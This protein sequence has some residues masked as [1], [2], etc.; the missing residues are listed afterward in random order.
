MKKRNL[1]GTL[2]AC[3]ACFVLGTLSSDLLLSGRPTEPPKDGPA[4]AMEARL[5]ANIYLQTS[6]EYRA[7]CQQIYHLAGQRMETIL[8][9]S[10][11]PPERPAVVM[12]L[13]ETVLDNSA[14]QTFLYKNKLEYTDALWAEFEEKHA[15]EVTFIPGAREFITKANDLGVTVVFISNRSE[16]FRKSTE[17]ILVWGRQDLPVQQRYALYLRPKDGSHDKSSRREAVAAKYNVLM[18][19]GDSLRDFSESFRAKTLVPNAS[20]EDYRKAI[21]ERQAQVDE[22]SC[23]WGV[24]WFVLPNPVYGEWEKLIG[25]DPHAII[26]PHQNAIASTETMILP[27]REEDQASGGRKPR[28]VS[29]RS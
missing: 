12:D 23:H 29:W 21:R 2:L 13:D 4:I 20:T 7:C 3:L 8:R 11:P 15:Q 19:F 10:N 16:T 28:L 5:A 17:S 24:D 9:S 22:A 6:G 25:P 14:F 1:Y 18:F 26:H 27:R